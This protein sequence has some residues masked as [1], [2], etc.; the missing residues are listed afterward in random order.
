MGRLGP[1]AMVLHAHREASTD[2]HGVRLYITFRHAPKEGRHTES[3]GPAVGTPG[4]LT[5]PAQVS[6]AA[7]TSC[8]R[9]PG[10][11]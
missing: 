8:R 3:H 2:R 1:T 11:F 10:G 4:H 6:M 7:P 9:P 5:P